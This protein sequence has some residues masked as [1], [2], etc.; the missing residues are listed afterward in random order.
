MAPFDRSH[1]GSYSP[2]IVTVVLSCI[3]YEIQRLTG[4]KSRHFY[5]LPVFSGPAGGDHVEIL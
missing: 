1:T 2:T 4:R 3:V 5:T